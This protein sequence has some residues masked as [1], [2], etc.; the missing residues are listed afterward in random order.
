MVDMIRAPSGGITLQTCM[1]TVK[2]PEGMAI[3][4]FLISANF[5]ENVLPLHSTE[6]LKHLQQ[7][8]VISVDKQPLDEIRDYFGTEIAMYFS[9][10]GHMTTALW[11][12]ALLG[13]S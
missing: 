13:L 3:V 4:P 5:V 11:F 8:W 2:I 10:L 6:F 1:K 12:P 9:W 7:K